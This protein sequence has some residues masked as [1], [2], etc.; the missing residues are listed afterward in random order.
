MERKIKFNKNTSRDFHGDPEYDRLFLRTRENYLTDLL[1]AD[2]YV[3]MNYIYEILGLKW[4]PEWN[5][6]CITRKN[7][8]DIRFKVRSVKN[9]FNVTIIW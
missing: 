9:G 3:Y 1:I 5:N 4:N 7:S 8:D 2:G 6:T